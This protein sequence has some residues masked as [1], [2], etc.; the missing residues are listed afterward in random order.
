M[1]KKISYRDGKLDN[2]PWCG[3]PAQMVSTEIWRSVYEVEYQYKVECSHYAF[4]HKGCSTIGKKWVEHPSSAAKD[5]N[6]GRIYIR[7]NIPLPKNSY[8]LSKSYEEKN[9]IAPSVYSLYNAK[10]KMRVFIPG[11]RN[12]SKKFLDL[13]TFIVDQETLSFKPY[14]FKLV[15]PH[16]GHWYTVE[17]SNIEKGQRINSKQMP[18]LYFDFIIHSTSVYQSKTNDSSFLNTEPAHW[19]INDMIFEILENG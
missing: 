18:D 17:I 14:S 6:D 11:Q 16:N 12:I 1:L 15:E 7:L 19:P 9:G 4:V 10:G 8:I 2:C 5:W 3:S 13:L